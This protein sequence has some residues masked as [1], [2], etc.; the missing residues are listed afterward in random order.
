MTGSSDGSVRRE[1]VNLTPVLSPAS[2]QRRIPA[3]ALS[4]APLTPRKASCA[5][6]TPSKLIP[7]YE[8]PALFRA[9]ASPSPMA[10]PFVERTVLS[11]LETANEES[12][13]RSGLRSGSPPEKRRTGT[14]YDARSSIIARASAVASS[15]SARRP[16]ASL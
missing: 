5:S 6:P 16:F 3:A 12:A 4:N 13:R 15:S 9:A 1:S 7:T 14:P 8:K 11:P 2:R 10:V